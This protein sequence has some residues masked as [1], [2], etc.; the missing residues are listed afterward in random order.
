MYILKQGTRWNKPERAGTS[1]NHLERAGT[2]KNEL[3]RV[4]M[5]C[6]YQR[7]ALGRIRVVTWSGS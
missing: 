6:S 2:N 1:Q 4:E 3:N 7:L 5:R